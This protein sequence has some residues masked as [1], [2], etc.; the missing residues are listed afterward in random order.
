MATRSLGS[1]TLDLVAK[2]GGFT[3]GMDEAER[4]ADRKS[5][6]IARK[7]K[8]R[9]KEVEKAWS[10]SAKWIGGAFAGLS[11]AG[12]LTKFIQESIDAQNEQ[13]QLAA[14]LRST[15]EA[16]GFTA[17]EL[18]KMSA[19][20]A[21]KS[22][23]SDGEITAAQTRLL[24]YTG[25]VGEQFPEAMQAVIDMSAR[26]GM[27]LEQ[28]A[29]T[30]GKALDV[31]SKGLTA[32]SKQGF[33]FTEDQKKMAERLEASGRT[34]E[35]Q[36]IILDALKSSYGGAAEAARNTFGGAIQGLRNELN[37]LI[38]GEDGSLGGAT[39][40]INGLTN[41]LQS[42]ETKQ[43]FES[44]T[45]LI[46]GTISLLVRGSAAFLQFGQDIGRSLSFR[47]NGDET[48]MQQ[49]Q[50]RAEELQAAIQRTSSSIDRMSE[51]LSRDPGND[52]LAQRVE[53][54]RERLADLMRQAADTSNSLKQV[55]NDVTASPQAT[56]SAAPK[57]S[58]SSGRPL[59]PSEESIKAAER[60]EKA[61]QAYL[62]KLQLQLRGTEDLS[63][64]ETVLRDLQEGRLKLA[65]NVTKERLVD[66]ARQIDMEKELEAIAKEF[67][68]LEEE[69]IE[70]KKALKDAGQAVYDATRTPAEQ[71][72]I[73]LARLNDLLAKGAID[74]DTYS[75]AV[76]GAQ[77]AFEAAANGG[78]KAF[79]EMDQFS[80]NAA[81]NIQ[82]AIGSGLADILNGEYEDIGK[83][84]SK[85]IM[86]MIAEAQAAKIARYLFGDMVSGGTG[87]GA[88]GDIFKTF[89]SW[90]TGSPGR[91][92][93][94]P[95]MAG[96]LY[97]VNENS[98]EML[99]LGGKQ[100]LMMGNQGGKVI[101]TG[102][103]SMVAGGSGAVTVNVINQGGGNLAVT[104]QR[105]T[106]GADGS[107]NID[108]MV[109][110][111][112][113]MMADNLANGSGSLARAMEG[114]YG[115]RTA[116]S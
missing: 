77:D 61:A 103:G 67:K 92:N 66:I 115:L 13:A 62:E 22:I 100:Y 53:K 39:E 31:P 7:Q 26:M 25:I 24:S 48:G 58:T 29:E 4:V 60:A 89:M 35:A 44:L 98:P 57:K 82:G 33:R 71:L 55:A 88:V 52:F 16:A 116:V 87:S 20:M 3:R 68:Q 110:A 40:A 81:E 72:N 2:I 74:W 70:R 65:G 94:G 69:S 15:G 8:A 51:A 63:A 11:I 112:Q 9:A 41:V 43:A 5:R 47:I 6:D 19:E 104:G 18:N 111:I 38:T 85:M 79:D 78:K 73:E 50:Q 105:Q 101:P 54:A 36:A 64:A 34:A 23:F 75:R 37:S 17:T 56:S 84:F 32:L 27:S 42:S 114:R 59:A 109:E 46:A 106:R 91:A 1:L 96:G 86:R 93:G 76:F 28:S 49:A 83:S 113:G 90:I 97:E 102:D 80:K 14:V 30:I 21:G 99:A 107:M 10:D 12:V 95:V 108:V 45:S